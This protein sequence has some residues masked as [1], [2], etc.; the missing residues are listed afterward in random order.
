MK[1][2]IVKSEI[3]KLMWLWA[4]NWSS[5]VEVGTPELAWH[6]MVRRV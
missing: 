5:G 4:D 3:E 6:G 1:F 2:K